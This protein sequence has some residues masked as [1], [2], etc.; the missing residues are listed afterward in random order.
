MA[1]SIS[2]CRSAVNPSTSF[3]SLPSAC[4]AGSRPASA[5]IVYAASAQHVLKVH[6]LR[7]CS[8]ALQYAST[9]A[10]SA[11][12]RRAASAS[13]RVVPKSATAF[14]SGASSSSSSGAGLVRSPTRPQR[15]S[16]SGP[17]S[18]GLVATNFSNVSKHACMRFAFSTRL[19]KLSP[20]G[21][22]F[23]LS[24]AP[25]T[26]VG[27]VLS[28]SC[29]D[30]R[31]LT[32]P[33]RKKRPPYPLAMTGADAPVGDVLGHSVKRLAVEVSANHQRWLPGPR[34]V[35]RG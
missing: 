21:S 33:H 13:Q 28:N 6:P 24:D 3:A 2:F 29:A 12:A 1:A 30:V 19:C 32:P 26:G 22:P 17:S 8:Q 27:G 16:N 7:T 5:R 18:C 20:V 9:A 14:G 15:S 31:L 25:P 4:N 34:A 11:P 23:P 35:R 10:P